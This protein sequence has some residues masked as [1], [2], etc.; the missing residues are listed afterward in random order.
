MGRIFELSLIAL[1]SQR[2]KKEEEPRPRDDVGIF[3]DGGRPF[4]LSRFGE[5]KGGKEGDYRGGAHAGPFLSPQTNARSYAELGERRKRRGGGKEKGG[6]KG[7]LLNPR[8]DRMTAVSCR[9]LAPLFRRDGVRQRVGPV[10]GGRRGKRKKE[11]GTS[12]S[13]IRSWTSHHRLWPPF[14]TSRRDRW[15]GKREE[16]KGRGKRRFGNDVFPAWS[17][18]SLAILLLPSHVH[19]QSHPEG[20]GGGKKEEKERERSNRP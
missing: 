18:Q 1:V 5:E 4:D 13:R 16:K 8:A 15:G 2:E 12:R 17:S 3:V 10:K 20:G 7:R 11:K 9:Y 6:G 14:I 19:E